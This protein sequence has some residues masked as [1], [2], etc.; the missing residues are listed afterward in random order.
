MADFTTS[1]TTKSAIRNL[2]EPLADV[3]AFDNLVQGVIASNPF[4]CVTY[5]AKGVN[6][7]PVERSREAY[8]ARIIYQDVDANTVGLVTIRAGT[9]AAFTAVANHILADA[10]VA[11]A[12]GGTAVRDSDSEKYSATLKCHDQNGEIYFVDF[13]RTQVRLS[14]YSDEAIR[15]RVETWADTVAALN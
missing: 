8:T 10:T 9:I 11:T 13:S 2:A 4:Q 6:H 3:T 12:I 5:N 15:S 1:T 7:A 14:S